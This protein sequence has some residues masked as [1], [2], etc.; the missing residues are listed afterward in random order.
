MYVQLRAYNFDVIVAPL[1]VSQKN[2]IY[3]NYYTK[4]QFV[5]AKIYSKN[6]RHK[7]R[8]VKLLR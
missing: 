1:M 7:I 3:N 5:S 8:T 2:L 4:G 6:I